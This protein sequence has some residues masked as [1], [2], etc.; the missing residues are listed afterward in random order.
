[1]WS[2]VGGFAVQPVQTERS[3][4]G[5][6]RFHSSR[7]VERLDVSAETSDQRLGLLQSLGEFSQPPRAI[8]R[9]HIS[10]YSTH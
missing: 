6:C 2:K 8:R 9:G 4:L 7:E 1:M 3:N 10:W 5:A